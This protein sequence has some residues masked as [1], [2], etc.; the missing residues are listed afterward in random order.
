MLEAR[1][2]FMIICFP[3]EVERAV[4]SGALFIF[5][6]FAVTRERILIADP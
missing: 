3:D 5:A 1:G 4:F 2:R 6:F